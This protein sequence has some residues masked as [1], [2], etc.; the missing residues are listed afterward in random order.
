M[1]ASSLRPSTL[2]LPQGEWATVLD[3]LCDHFP[4]IDRATWLQR[5]A[6]GKVLDGA[7]APIGA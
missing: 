1:S 7:G 6:R 4:A 3:C 2:H 5:M